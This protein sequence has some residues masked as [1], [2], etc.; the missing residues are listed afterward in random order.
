M[1]PIVLVKDAAACSG[2]GACLGVCPKEAITMEADVYGCLYPKIDLARC[3]HCGK[4]VQICPHCHQ[5]AGNKPV[6]VYAAVGKCRQTVQNSAS[7][8]VFAVLAQSCVRKGGLAAGAVMDCHDNYA[9]VYHLLSRK[10][11]DICRMQGSKYVQSEA[12]RSYSYVVQ[13]IKAGKTVLFSGTPCQVA[14]VKALTGNPDNLLTVDVI[15]HGVPP[16]QMLNDYLKVLSRRFC[17]EVTGF[18]FRDK[19]CDK[20]FTAKILL[21]KSGRTG[22]IHLRSNYLSF[23]KYFLT[24]G[25]YRESCYSCPYAGSTRVSDIT[26]GDYWGIEQFHGEEIRSGNMPDRKD[27]SC[28]LVNTEKGA[29]FLEANG[30]EIF[31]YPTRLEWVAEK[32]QQLRAPAIPDKNRDRILKLYAESGYPALEADFVKQHGGRLRFFWRMLR[33]LLENNRTVKK[34]AN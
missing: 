31:L 6:E 17:G 27:W 14:A 32:N 9:D 16:R 19:S 8:G 26:I 11:P 20:Q 4:C 23:Y 2:C 22:Q 13:A 33:N 30:E 5:W 1:E 3:V 18:C 34:H 21:R 10:E 28:I 7:G 29:R 15:C 25:I 24:G 12:W